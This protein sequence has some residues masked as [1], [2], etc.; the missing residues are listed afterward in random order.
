MKVEWGVDPVSNKI[1]WERL[2]LLP[3]ELIGDSNPKFV[4]DLGGGTGDFASSLRGEATTVI[5]LDTDREVLRNRLE[6][7]QAVL[8]DATVLPFK[9]G[10]IDAVTARAILHHFPALLPTSLKEVKRVLTNDGLF[11]VQEPLAGNCFA[12][13]A[14]R[15]FSTERH[16]EG[17]RPLKHDILKKAISR[18]FDLKWLEYHFLLS[19]LYPHMVH[20]IPGFLK[21]LARWEASIVHNLDAK[22]LEGMPKLRNYA[23]YLTILGKKT[24]VVQDL[25][26]PES[27]K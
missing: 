5:S 27:N 16:E 11:L 20:R 8:G 24:A 3:R 6:G 19:Y 2:S 26:P 23:A 15:Y 7:V 9:D 14:R 1:L 4:L 21:S 13:I 17:E 25:P 12:N 18:E 10:S 22:A